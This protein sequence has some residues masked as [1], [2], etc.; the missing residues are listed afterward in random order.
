MQNTKRFFFIGGVFVLVLILS[1]ALLAQCWHEPEPPAPL[2]RTSPY[3]HDAPE[4]P[5]VVDVQTWTAVEDLSTLVGRWKVAQG[6]DGEGGRVRFQ[7]TPTGPGRAS[8]PRSLYPW[9]FDYE[10][11]DEDARP[12]RCGFFEALQKESWRIAYCTGG[13]P[14]EDGG[15][16][17]AGAYAQRLSVHVKHDE[18]DDV[19]VQVGSLLELYINRDTQP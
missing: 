11:V 16:P 13:G 1:T 7:K 6:Y 18:P 4:V 12:L 14:L 19:R 8:E 3:P 9:R 5:V 15:Q 17:S 2:P 10:P